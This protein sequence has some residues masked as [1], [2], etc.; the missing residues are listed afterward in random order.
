MTRRSDRP[1]ASPSASLLPHSLTAIRMTRLINPPTPIAV[2]LNADGTPAYI[3]GSWS[4]PV[5]P[6]ARWKVETEW[7]VHAVVREHRK[8]VLNSELLC[9]LLPHVSRCERVIQQVYE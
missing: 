4:G 2:T 9:E 7:W 8:V 3:T 1:Q 5:D 6:I